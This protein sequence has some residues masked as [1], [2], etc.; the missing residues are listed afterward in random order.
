MVSMTF[1][2]I[3]RGLRVMDHTH[4]CWTRVSTNH[5]E[6]QI[7]FLPFDDFDEAE[8]KNSLAKDHRSV[9]SCD[10]CLVRLLR[11]ICRGRCHLNCGKSLFDKKKVSNCSICQLQSS[12]V[13]LCHHK[14]KYLQLL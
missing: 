10:Q 11:A 7:D 9:L 13:M 1:S 12:S 8:H 6:S 3:E 4:I 2:G 5:L 14:Q